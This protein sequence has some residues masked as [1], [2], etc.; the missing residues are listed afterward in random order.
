MSRTTAVKARTKKT[1][2]RAASGDGIVNLLIILKNAAIKTDRDNC[3]GLAKEAAY[4]FILSFFPM[5]VALIALF[6][7]LGDPAQSVR[8]ILTTL[9]RM[10][11]ADSY[12]L[13]DSYIAGYIKSMALKPQGK[14]FSL[15]LAGT[16]WTASGI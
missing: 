7:M 4:S 14:L 9:R 6:F 1:R 3:I 2:T 8:E 15:S 12:K 10:L 13:I 5:L 16:L 11:P